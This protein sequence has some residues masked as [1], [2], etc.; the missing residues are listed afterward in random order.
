MK[1]LI[2]AADLEQLVLLQILVQLDLHFLALVKHSDGG[3]GD[4]DLL[5]G[6]DQLGGEDAIVPDHAVRCFVFLNLIFTQI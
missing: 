6:I 4:T 1:D 5:T 2:A 3:A